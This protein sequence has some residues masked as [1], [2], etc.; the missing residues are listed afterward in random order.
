MEA[1]GSLSGGLRR[2]SIRGD[3]AEENEEKLKL[4]RGN[5][6]ILETGNNCPHRNVHH[7]LPSFWIVGS[8]APA[9]DMLG[10]TYGSCLLTQDHCFGRL[11]TTLDEDKAELLIADSGGNVVRLGPNADS[12][13]FSD[14]SDGSCS[15]D[16][17]SR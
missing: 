5:T 10:A 8:N 1:C 7:H 16:A 9:A 12:F 11:P 15:K 13:A 14:T 17:R 4:T 3:G 6:S 2:V